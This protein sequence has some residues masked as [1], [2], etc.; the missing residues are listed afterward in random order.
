MPDDDLRK[1]HEV[2]QGWARRLCP[3]VWPVDVA[4]KRLP[5]PTYQ[6]DNAYNGFTG[7]ERRR[8]EQVLQV[9]RR[10]GVIAKPD[11]CDICG[12][13]GRIGFHGEDYFDPFSMAALCFPCHMALHRRFKSPDKWHAL[14]ECNADSPRI[15]DFH[16]LPMVEVDFA[17]WLRENTD[18]PHDVV[19]Q[20]WGDREVPDYVPRKKA[21][22]DYA[23]VISD[24]EPSET[25][26]RALSVLAANPGA[27]STELTA[28]M[29]WKGDSAWHLKFGQFCRRFE[30]ALGPAPEV[31]TRR[32]PDGSPARFHIGLI[33]DF[34]QESR[35][36]TLMPEIH[37]ALKPLLG[38]Q[39][40]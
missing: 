14:L 10:R 36:F 23:K 26:W 16:A 28:L 30:P 38:K 2:C 6:G 1:L 12:T 34:D 21:G 17:S 15:A 24:A 13:T 40:G 35:G 20:V 25:E 18:G 19:K 9:L 33:A 4:V 7:A 8:G 32:N 37:A 29:G 3:T 11:V 22:P 5:R 27:T 31:E 39:D